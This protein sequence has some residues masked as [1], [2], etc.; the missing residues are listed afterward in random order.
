MK[1]T[2]KTRKKDLLFTSGAVYSSDKKTKHPYSIISASKVNNLR[3]KLI[4]SYTQPI[5]FGINGENNI[6][7]IVH[8]IGA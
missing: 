4:N 3:S 2:T 8:K 7:L 6:Y 1:F 5:G